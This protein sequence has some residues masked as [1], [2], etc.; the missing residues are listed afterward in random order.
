[1]KLATKY[2][3]YEDILIV[4]CH[5]DCLIGSYVVLGVTEPRDQIQMVVSTPLL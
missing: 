3:K 4:I 5:H 2:L 1:L